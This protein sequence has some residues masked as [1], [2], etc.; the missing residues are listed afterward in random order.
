MSYCYLSTL[1]SKVWRQ[2]SSSTEKNLIDSLTVNKLYN[3]RQLGSYLGFS[4]SLSYF[5]RQTNNT[6]VVI[7]TDKLTILNHLDKEHESS[8]SD[9]QTD[10]SEP[11]W[12]R[13]KKLLFW[14]TTWQFWTYW[15]KNKKVVILTDNLTIL[16]HLDKEHESSYFDWQ[17]DNSE[18]T[19][20]SVF[21][22][23]CDGVASRLNVTPARMMVS[24]ER[25]SRGN[26]HVTTVLTIVRK[27]NEEL[28]EL[29]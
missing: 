27:R 10:N 6:K 9:W 26:T 2:K 17:I 3:Y 20:I 24:H 16:N 21:L 29:Q 11:T 18:P 7:L 13:T 1:L 8:Y 4:I 14:L 19:Q 22:S 28:R 12:Q 23:V 5:W 25:L 15:T